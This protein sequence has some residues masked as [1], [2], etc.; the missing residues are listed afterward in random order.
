M[1]FDL[2][3]GMFIASRGESYYVVW[4]TNFATTG[5]DLS[6][7]M[8]SEFWFLFFLFL[9]GFDFWAYSCCPVDLW[10]LWS[11][12]SLHNVLWRLLNFCV[13]ED[14]CYLFTLKKSSRIF[15]GLLK[16]LIF[17]SLLWASAMKGRLWFVSSSPNSFS[18]KTW[19]GINCLVLLR[20]IRMARNS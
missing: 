19:M 6:C 8:N 12:F 11:L 18:S 14:L 15:L 10:R 1:T 7:L 16:S 3:F 9:F 5:T 20:R 17:I 4:M 2:I 13:G